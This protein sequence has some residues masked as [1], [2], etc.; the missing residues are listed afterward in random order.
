MKKIEKNSETIRLFILINYFNKYIY[1]FS[2]LYFSS[3]TSLKMNK[4]SNKTKQK[5]S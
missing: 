2:F 1:N 4:K 5:S 3:L